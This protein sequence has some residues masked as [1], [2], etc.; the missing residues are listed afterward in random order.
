MTEKKKRLVELYNNIKNC[1]RCW[2]RNVYNCP[3]PFAGS[4][5]AICLFVGEAPGEEE[6]V[7]GK[8]FVGKSGKILRQAVEDA[9]I[10]KRDIII[11]NTIL[12]RPPNN[13]FPSD[14]TVIDACRI[15]FDYLFDIIQPEIVVAIGSKPHCY[16]RQRV[17]S[18]TSACGVWEKWT[19]NGKEV[20]YIATLHPSFCLRPGR[21]NSHNTIMRMTRE[22]KINLLLEHLFMV[23]NKIRELKNEQ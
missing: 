23:K 8:P 22:E 9:G 17:D 21:A 13:N 3:T 12:C 18:I 5:E 4:E 10:D 16:I 19:C 7:Q 1:K 15:W 6:F 14:R 20:F 2:L 11:T